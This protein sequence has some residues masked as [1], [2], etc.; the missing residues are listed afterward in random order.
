MRNTPSLFLAVVVVF[1]GGLSAQAG[2]PETVGLVPQPAHVSSNTGRFV[3]SEGVTIRV[4][5]DSADAANVATSW[6]TESAL[7]QGCGWQSYHPTAA[8]RIMPLY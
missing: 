3:L 1:V 7:A 6:P 8:L 5:R 4:D 2:Q